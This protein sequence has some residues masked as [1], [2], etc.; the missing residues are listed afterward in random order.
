MVAGLTTAAQISAL[1]A[2]IVSGASRGATTLLDYGYTGD[3]AATKNLRYYQDADPGAVADG[4]LWISSTKSWE[5][6]GGAWRPYVGVGSVGT[7]ELADLAA[8]EIFNFRIAGPID[9]RTAAKLQRVNIPA[10]PFNTK[11]LVTATMTFFITPGGTP[12]IRRCWGSTYFDSQ[13]GGTYENYNTAPNDSMN[14]FAPSITINGK[15][16]AFANSASWIDLWG[17]AQGGVSTADV[18]GVNLRVE[19]IKK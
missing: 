12:I 19:V 10:Y 11:I 2:L 3:L 13:V 16:D 1:G 6:V 4:S 14:E 15:F 17:Q 7:G 18:L 5:R 8:T 9:V